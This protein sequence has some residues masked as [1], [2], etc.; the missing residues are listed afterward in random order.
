MTDSTVS[1]NTVDGSAAG[2]GEIGGGGIFLDDQTDGGS[3][4]H[5]IVNDNDVAALAGQTAGGGGLAQEEADSNFSINR[6]AFF[7]NTVDAGTSGGGAIL[8][9]DDDDP[10]GVLSIQNTTIDGN[11]GGS[12]FSAGGGLFVR[13]GAQAKV[14]NVTFSA[15]TSQFGND[16]LLVDGT[17]SVR[18]S[19]FFSSFGD[20]CGTTGGGVPAITSLGYNV[21]STSS[22]C[23][24]SAEGDVEAAFALDVLANN[25]GSPSRLPLSGAVIDHI[26]A[27]KCLGTDGGPLTVDQRGISRPDDANNDGEFECEAGAVELEVSGPPPPPPP[28]ASPPVMSPPIPPA[29]QAAA[30]V[31]ARKKCKRKKK[32]SA[33]AKKKCKKK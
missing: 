22:D 31:P 23:S 9:D 1:D 7:S 26:P 8:W 32:R 29:A 11:S 17:A 33:A 15:N 14:A 19:V 6:S 16:A 30:Q 5:S 25:G 28:P 13:I 21:A 24:F 12:N 18:G 10:R 27:S 2:A 20:N 3:I 4:E